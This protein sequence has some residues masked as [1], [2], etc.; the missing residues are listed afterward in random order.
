[1]PRAERIGLGVVVSPDAAVLEIDRLRQVGGDR[2]HAVAGDVVEPLDD[3]GDRAPRARDLTGFAE[4]R[5]A[6]VLL[7]ARDGVGRP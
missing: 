3:L 1:M 2:Q 6:D 5:D 7:G 4:Q